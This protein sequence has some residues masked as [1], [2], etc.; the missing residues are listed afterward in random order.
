M[1]LSRRRWLI[2][3]IPLAQVVARLT[4]ADQGLDQFKASGPDCKD[5]EKATPAVAADKTYKAGSPARTSFVEPRTAGATPLSLA[6]TVTGLTCGRIKG[7]RVDIWHADATGVYDMTGQRYRG[8][9]LTDAE[10]RFHLDT[11][12][13]GVSA[14]RA[15]HLGVNVQ[16]PGKANFWTELFFP[17]EAANARD[18]RFNPALTLRVRQEKTGRVATFDIVLDL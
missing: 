12:V 13:P 17:D 11:I 16:V 6:G 2:L 14:G 15:R 18:T 10:G 4:A 8:Y 9:Q 5:S 7:A 1:V 3:G